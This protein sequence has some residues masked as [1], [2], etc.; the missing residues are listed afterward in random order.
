MYCIEEPIPW[1]I[2]NLPSLHRPWFEPMNLAE[3]IWNLET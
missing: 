1:T 3:P 2:M